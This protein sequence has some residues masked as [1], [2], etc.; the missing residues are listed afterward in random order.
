MEQQVNPPL[1]RLRGY[2][3]LYYILFKSFYFTSYL[4]CP[5]DYPN[6]LKC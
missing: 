3:Y 1:S 5:Q 4:S 6:I 2:S